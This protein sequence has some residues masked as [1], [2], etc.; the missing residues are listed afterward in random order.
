MLF[1]E[2]AEALVGGL[3]K[4]F[5]V[6]SEFIMSALKLCFLLQAVLAMP[7]LA[8]TPSEQNRPLPSQAKQ[9]HGLAVPVPKEIF[10]SLD[11][12][13]DANWS[14]V[15][16]PRSGAM[17]ITWGSDADRNSAR[18]HDSRRF[19]CNGSERLDRGKKHRQQGAGVSSRTWH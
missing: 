13:P 4:Y 15:K 11:Q 3:K 9:V 12:F 8:Q 7:A 18:S 6:D 5:R 16:T 19:H 10:H 14:L 2:K 17:E 1:S